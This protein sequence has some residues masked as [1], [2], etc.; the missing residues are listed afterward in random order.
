M[1]IR[2]AAA[3]LIAGFAVPGVAVAQCD[4]RIQ[5]PGQVRYQGADG[6]G[7]Q[8]FQ[9]S[10]FEEPFTVVVSNDAGEVCNGLLSVQHT[11]RINGLTGIPPNFLRYLITL[12]GSV[13][14]IVDWEGLIGRPPHA[15]PVTIPAGGSQIQNLAFQ[16]PPSQTVPAGVYTQT[17]LVRLIDANDLSVISE[18][19]I[20][21]VSGV[22]SAMSILLFDGGIPATSTTPGGTRQRTLDFGTLQDGEQAGVTVLVQSNEPYEVRFSSAHSGALEHVTRGSSDK[23]PYIA[24]F[25]GRELN[26]TSGET[27]ISESAATGVAGLSRPLNVRIG[28]VGTARAGRYE[29]ELVITVLPV[30]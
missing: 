27:V 21:L 10:R 8:S 1:R 17:V 29:D 14:T 4:I 19:S 18:R 28:Q 6:T 22:P 16:I 5:S 25:G 30:G 26:L 11:D 9:S 23:V 2:L 7:Y 24:T 15:I 3:A 20:E 13:S 12:P